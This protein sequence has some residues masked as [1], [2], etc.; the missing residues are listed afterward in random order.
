L[1]IESA[2]V[3]LLG[4]GNK[5]GK[6]AALA[7]ATSVAA[8]ELPRSGIHLYASDK[9]QQDFSVLEKRKAPHEF[10]YHQRE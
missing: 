4:I 5:E 9:P 3:V 8:R 2:Q 6:I 7:I 10:N 1:R